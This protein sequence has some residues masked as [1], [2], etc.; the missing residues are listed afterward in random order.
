MKS[1]DM[2]VYMLLN[3]RRTSNALSIRLTCHYYQLINI[4]TEHL[5]MGIAWFNSM[6]TY[7]IRIIRHFDAKLCILLIDYQKKIPGPIPFRFRLIV[8]DNKIIFHKSYLIII[9]YIQ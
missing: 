7:K 1:R 4:K 5:D 6:C 9:Y 2:V 8:D 3:T